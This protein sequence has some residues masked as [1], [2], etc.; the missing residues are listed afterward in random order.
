[1]SWRCIG[2][3]HRD[4]RVEASTQSPA[5]GARRGGR[6]VDRA[7]GRLREDTAAATTAGAGNQSLD[8]CPQLVW[9]T[10]VVG[11]YTYGWGTGCRLD[12]LRPDHAREAKHGGLEF[13]KTG[14]LVVAPCT[15]EIE[16]S[17]YTPSPAPEFGR[18]P[19]D[20]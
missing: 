1:M 15:P 20:S 4:Q 18:P 7:N 12:D 5:P 10:A 3:G 17:L 2:S 6:T 16:G 14:Q 13:F 9:I 8:L 19:S 11:P